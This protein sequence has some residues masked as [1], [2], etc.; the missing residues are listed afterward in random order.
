MTCEHCNKSVRTPRFRSF[1]DDP[2][3]RK[4]LI[5]DLCSRAQRSRISFKP[6]RA[7]E[8]AR[9]AHAFIIYEKFRTQLPR[10]KI[11]VWGPSPRV[12]D[13]G[14]RKRGQIRQDLEQLDHDVA[15]SEDLGF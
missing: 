10:F 2:S 3:R 1:L 5:C 11:L 9:I 6:A 15:F 12:D 7:R 14:S 8:R 13:P 4:Y